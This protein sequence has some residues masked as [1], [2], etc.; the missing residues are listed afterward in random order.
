M[1][2]VPSAATA[3]LIGVKGDRITAIAVQPRTDIVT[4]LRVTQLLLSSV[5]AIVLELRLL[6]RA[7]SL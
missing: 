1:L 6:P 5:I 7:I 3:V 4:G 2:V